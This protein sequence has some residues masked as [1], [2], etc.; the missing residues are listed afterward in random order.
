M[1]YHT[2]GNMAVIEMPVWLDQE[3]AVRLLEDC[4]YA[5]TWPFRLLDRRWRAGFW[6]MGW[7]LLPF[8]IAINATPIDEIRIFEVIRAADGFDE[9]DPSWYEQ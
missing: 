5:C 2:P 8:S 4:Q 3:P 9:R 7:G 1:K 6:S